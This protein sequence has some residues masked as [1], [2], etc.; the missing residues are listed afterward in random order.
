[1]TLPFATVQWR[2]P[3]FPMSIGGQEM[4]ATVR[5][6]REALPPPTHLAYYAG[7][8]ALAVFA[9]VEWPV[10][11]IAAAGMIVVHRT[12]RRKDEHDK[13]SDAPVPEKPE[14]PARPGKS[15]E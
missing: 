6:V 3:D 11:M 13:E 15:A 12:F 8:G 9:I 4:Q 1:M 14:K 5:K 10:V 2:Q 7:L